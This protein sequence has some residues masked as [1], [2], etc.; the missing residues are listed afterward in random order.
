MTEAY[1]VEAVRTPIGSYRGALSGVRPDDLAA[2]VIAAVVERSG[3][4]HTIT[5]HGR[6]NMVKSV[7]WTPLPAV[8]RVVKRSASFTPDLA[9]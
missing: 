2:R 3:I 5:R 4:D 6:R 9:H 7:A 8:W 1:V